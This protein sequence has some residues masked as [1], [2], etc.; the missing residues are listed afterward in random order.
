M[1]HSCRYDLMSAFTAW[2]VCDKYLGC[3]AAEPLESGE[4]EGRV[5]SN[6]GLY[7]AF[8]C[9]CSLFSTSARFTM[10]SLNL[11][12]LLREARCQKGVC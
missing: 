8:L 11:S 6:P 9:V 5:V 7:S 1:R 12:T 4:Q 3:C 2:F 10:M